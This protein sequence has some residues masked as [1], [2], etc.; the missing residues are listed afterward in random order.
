M[1]NSV[2]WV[3]LSSVAVPR[4][5]IGGPFG[6]VLG[7]KDYVSE[8]IPVI[9]GQNLSSDGRFCADTFAYVTPQKALGVLSRNLAQPGDVIFTQRGTLGQVGLV[10]P[11]PYDTY[12]ISQSQMRL[13]VDPTKADVRYVY[14]CFRSPAIVDSIERRATATGVPHI[15]LGTLA[16][17]RMP[18]RPLPEQ[19]AIA[20]VL[21]A[22]DDKLEANRREVSTTSKLIAATWRQSFG[23]VRNSGWPR[24]PIGHLVTVVGGSTPSTSVAEFWGGTIAW[25]TPK[26][27]SKLQSAPIMDTER[28]ITKQGLKQISSG[29]LPVG[30]VLLSSRAPIG[31]IAVAELPLAVNQ[32]FI[33]LLVGERVS[34]L[35]LWQWLVAHLDEVRCRAN[36]TTFLEVSKAN[37]RPM[38]I[39]VP[40]EGLMRSWNE[41]VSSE[42]RLIVAREREIQRLTTLRDT[43]LPALLSGEVRVRD[44]E[45]LREAVI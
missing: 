34:N 12:V 21:G 13:R 38:L 44:A 29:L 27:L 6:S 31:Y 9:R 1:P 20:E 11:E 33:A 23:P 43:L 24:M 4:G 39:A 32:G 25:A 41:S 10:P 45:R 15:N 14:Y 35:Y 40:P 22:L 42:Y 8:G 2:T 19:H 30:T 37:F 7:R 5:L 16:D 3:P 28:R 17:I 18:L 36:G 26:D